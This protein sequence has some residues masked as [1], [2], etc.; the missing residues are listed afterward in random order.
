MPKIRLTGHIDVP[1]DRMDA[2]AAAL[3]EHIRLTHA[4]PGCLSFEVLPDPSVPGR[5]SVAELYA[6][7]ADFEAH[8][9]RGAASDWGKISAGIPRSYE[10]T[11]V[12]E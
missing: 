5:F 8:Q 1:E 9:A 7:R 4:E 10:I 11:E 2:I 3:P 12:S 6:S